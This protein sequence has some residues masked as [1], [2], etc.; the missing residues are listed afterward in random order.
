M[1]AGMV[2]NAIPDFYI[3]SGQNPVCI[4]SRCTTAAAENERPLKMQ[5][6]PRS[7]YTTGEGGGDSYNR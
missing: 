4:L 1:I 5:S 6:T 7:F 2:L 3:V